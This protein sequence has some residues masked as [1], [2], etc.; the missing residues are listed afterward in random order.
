MQTGAA[1]DNTE[2]YEPLDDE[3]WSEIVYCGDDE[4]GPSVLREA[5]RSKDRFSMD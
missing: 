4:I 2:G 5:V 1:R 3:A